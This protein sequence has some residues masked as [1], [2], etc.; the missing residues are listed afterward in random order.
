MTHPSQCP[1]LIDF[2]SI[3]DTAANSSGSFGVNYACQT[4][5][6]VSYRFLMEI[7]IL[8]IRGK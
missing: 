4:T 2:R 3:T 1:R 8:A 5:N 6:L 7:E